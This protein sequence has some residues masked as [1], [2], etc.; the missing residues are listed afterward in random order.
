MKKLDDAARF[1]RKQL[2]DGNRVV[3][4][5]QLKSDLKRV[6]E[7]IKAPR[8][9]KRLGNVR[10][11]PGSVAKLSQP[12]RN[13]MKRIH[14]QIAAGGNRGISGAVSSSDAMKLGERFVGPGYRVMSGNKGLISADGLR[15]FRF[16]AAKRGISPA[17]GQ[18]WSNTSVQV[19]FQSRL[20]AIGEW[21]NNVHLDIL[22]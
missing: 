7:A 17:T 12:L 1:T 16:P 21:L 8:G 18:P 10:N 19:N 3:G 15:Q 5:D 11:D 9:K 22:K 2:Y 13:K 14:N 4:Y 6:E 20:E